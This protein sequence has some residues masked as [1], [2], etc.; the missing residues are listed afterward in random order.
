M[1][2][3][4]IKPAVSSTIDNDKLNSTKMNYGTKKWYAAMQ[5]SFVVIDLETTGFSPK[6]E[7]IIEVCAI[8]YVNGIETERFSTLV[9][10]KKKINPN[11]TKINNITDDMVADKPIFADIADKLLDLINDS[12]LVAHNAQFDLSFLE[13]A[14]SKLEYDFVCTYVDT[15]T[16]ARKLFPELPNHKLQTVLDSIGFVRSSQHRSETDCEGCAAIIK[17]AISEYENN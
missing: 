10:P 8:K 1:Q 4:D 13:A 2:S 12:V 3:K 16:I 9:N 6:Y 7:K 15:L 5:N 11:A 17:R 14:F